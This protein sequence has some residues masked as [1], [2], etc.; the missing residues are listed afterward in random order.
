MNRHKFF[1]ESLLVGGIMFL[2]IAAAVL[3][4][5]REATR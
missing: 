4:V 3:Y 5:V 2:L 1:H